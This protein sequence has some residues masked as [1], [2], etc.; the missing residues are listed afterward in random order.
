MCTEWE[1]TGLLYT[2]GELDAEAS[3]RFAAHLGSCSACRA[4]ITRYQD[5]REGTFGAAVFE[6]VPPQHVDRAILKAATHQRV[7][8]VSFMFV[9]VLIRRGVVAVVMLALGFGSG[10]YVSQVSPS[11]RSELVQ[12][13]PL[14]DA[15]TASATDVAPVADDTAQTMVTASSDSA[16]PAREQGAA[17]RVFDDQEARRAAQQVRP[18]AQQ[19]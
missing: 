4:E 6:E 13:A 17:P 18:V 1:T 2:S 19:R 9:P 10:I 7:V 12:D 11:G 15:R 3:V 14:P 16:I 5:E 8:P